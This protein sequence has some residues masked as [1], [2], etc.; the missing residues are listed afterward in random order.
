MTEKK[1]LRKLARIEQLF[2][3]QDTFDNGK[4]FYEID[5]LIEEVCEYED[6]HYLTKKSY[7]YMEA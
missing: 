4:Y 7:G 3:E 5:F 1:Y 6:E 2:K